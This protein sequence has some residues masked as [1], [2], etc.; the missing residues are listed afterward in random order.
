MSPARKHLN[1]FADANR[2]IELAEACIRTLEAMRG[3][4]AQHCIAKL[5]R[6]QQAA[7]KR[8]DRAAEKLGAPYG[9]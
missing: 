5:K 9:S 4:T 7:L 6:E 1:D 8:L 3:T 2:Q